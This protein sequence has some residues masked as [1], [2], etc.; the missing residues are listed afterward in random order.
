MGWFENQIEERR[1][2]DQELLDAAFL[3]MAGAVLGKHTGQMLKS[4][5]IITKKAIDE[6]LKFYHY[7]PC[8]IPDTIENAEEQ[9]DYCLAPHGIMSRPVKLTGEWYKD[10]FG[11]LIAFTTESKVPVALLPGS[12]HGY[13]YTDPESGARVKLNKRTAAQLESE[14][15]CFYRPLPTKKLGIGDLLLYMKQ[16]VSVGD[17]VQLVIALCMVS[18]LGLILPRMAEALT[19]PVIESGAGTALAG[20]AVCVCCVLFASH[21]M[22]TVRDFA[23]LRMLTKTSLSVR[24]AMMM[25]TLSL[26]AEFFRKYNPGD[27]CSRMSSLDELCVIL[28]GVVMTSVLA[29]VTSLIYVLQI[30]KFTPALAATVALVVLVSAGVSA[31]SAAIKTREDRELLLQEARESGASYAFISGIQKIKLAGAEKRVFAKWLDMHAETFE[32]KYEPHAIIKLN[33]VITTAIT[34]IS[35]IAL[36]YIAAK[37]GISASSYIAFNTS[38][39]LLMGSF[40]VL[41]NVAPQAACVKPILDMC[42]PI[43][44]AE[45]ERTY[46]REI[47]TRL[48]GA[49]ELEKVSFRYNDEQPYV[50]KDLSFRVR[51]GEYVAVVGK[52]GC[53]K[54]T[55]I[56]LL[57]GFERPEKGAVYYD[58]RNLSGLDQPSLRRRIGTVMQNSELLHGSIY[59]NIAISSP[60]LSLEEAWEAAETAGIADD[61]RSMPMG[62]HTII[63]EGQGS[64]SGGQKQRIIIARAIAA[65]PRILLFDEATSALDN[66]TQHKVSE[67]LDAMKC[68]RLIIA[69]R[70][71]TIKHCDRILVLDGGE[72]VES[73]TYEELLAKNGSFAELVARQ[74]LE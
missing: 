65:K 14:A 60:G 73:G 45:P 70:L 63:S 22:E 43:L 3:R 27:L 34:L 57:L 61:I 68:T 33:T 64:I 66:K 59:E 25:R 44:K 21:I 67:A 35:T 18:F 39:G 74:R 23:K 55:I 17:C 48:S 56:R 69:H 58:G 24:S 49:V 5:R 16:C 42:E 28:L 54:S 9:M 7:M 46:G 2:A 50:L 29:A 40:T 4:K 31:V 53:G 72:I 13:Y 51:P 36:Y 37:N 38:Y 52:S 12:M 15:V 62:M 26:P 30:L 47:V 41:V 6:I 19:G 71:S 10:S 20:A 8:E 32:L 11:P 1:R